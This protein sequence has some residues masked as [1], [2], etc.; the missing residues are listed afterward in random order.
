MRM[1]IAIP[2]KVTGKP[3]TMKKI[4]DDINQSINGSL[5]LKQDFTLQYLIHHA[6]R[7]DDITTIGDDDVIS[8]SF[9]GKATNTYKQIVGNYHF[10]DYDN[11]TGK[12]G[13]DILEV[14]SDKVTNFDMSNKDIDRDFR[15][16]EQTD[17]LELSERFLFNNE[18][19]LLELKVVS[20]LRLTNIEIGD[21]V[22]CEFTR[23]VNQPSIGDN[24]RVFFVTG[25]KKDSNR[26]ELKMSDLGNL[27]NR[28]AI[29]TDDSSPDHSSATVD[30]KRFSSYLTDDNGLITGD[31]DSKGS[32]LIS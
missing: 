27:F 15:V 3:P 20:D 29:I 16:F 6:E 17:A 25:V 30:D 1:S 32:D 11:S 7:V 21:R 8:W 18:Q 28:S 10:V 13:N 2:Y 4:I 12:L 22:V 14:S 23:L 24:K 31:D 9:N 19:T 26:I 5:S